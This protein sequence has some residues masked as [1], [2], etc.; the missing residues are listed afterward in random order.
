MEVFPLFKLLLKALMIKCT[1]SRRH[2]PIHSFYASNQL[3]GVISLSILVVH[4]SSKGGANIILT[5]QLGIG[6]LGL[7]IA[8]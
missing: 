1:I 6:M 7:T 5:W 4:E 3:P 2:F 8:V